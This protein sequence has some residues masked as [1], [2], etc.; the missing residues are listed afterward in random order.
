M[1]RFVW[2]AFLLILVIFVGWVSVKQLKT[3]KN[4]TSTE[5]LASTQTQE[6]A[7]ETATPPVVSEVLIEEQLK[8]YL[9]SIG[10]LSYNG[11][12]FCTHHLYGFDEDKENNQ[13]K[14]YVWAYCE[15]YYLENNQLKMGFGVSEPVL[16]TMETKDGALVATS[17]R[18]PG[19]GSLYAPSIK[20]MFPEKYAQ[21]AIN[22]FSV[23]QLKPSPKEQAEAFYNQ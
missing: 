14:V 10:E 19:N 5:S 1:K 3:Q 23:D 7:K 11:K 20:E 15:E 18:E 12:L 13:I 22:G 8:T 21:D 16:V 2:I 6:E 17:Y 9:P 4:E